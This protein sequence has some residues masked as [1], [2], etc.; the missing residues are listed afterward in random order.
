MTLGIMQ[1]YFFPYLGYYSLINQ[2]DQFI[3]FDTPQF[4]RHGWIERN[5]ILK[6][7]GEPHYIKMP[8]QKHSRDTPI[9]QII[10]NNNLPWKDK[11]LAQ[12]VMYKK[13]AKY[14][15]QVRKLVEQLFEFE[16]DSV[17]DWN[18]HILRG[19]CDYLEINTPINIF[20]KMNLEIGEVSAPDEWALEICK[21]IGS[22][23]Y[24]NLPGGKEF[25]DVKK[26][27]KS[28]I[29]LDFLNPLEFDYDQKTKEFV[30]NLSIIDVMM[31]NGKGSIK[32]VI[33][34]DFKSS[35]R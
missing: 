18:F 32:K 34:N 30:P 13:K 25:F 19:T 26:Y 11:I 24:I 6:P 10:V 27:Q 29:H 35:N 17:V 15:Y 4:I 22:D 3:L 31:F 33:D 21:T 1:P 20:S 5:R 14:Y 9:N 8:L 7:D 16:S 28:N 23:K 2:S 12:L